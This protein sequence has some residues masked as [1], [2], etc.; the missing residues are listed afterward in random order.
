[1]KKLSA[2]KITAMIV[3]AIL[4]LNLRAILAIFRA[5]CEWFAT[6]L[7]GLNDFPDGA[8]T[9]IAFTTLLLIAILIFRL[10]KK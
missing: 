7:A 8:Q 6:S 10:V 2:K 3:A 1:M 9:A 5:T 4:L